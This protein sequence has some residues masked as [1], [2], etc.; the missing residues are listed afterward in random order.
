M[1]E[2]KKKT[3][4][5]KPV[6]LN[7]HQAM[8]AIMRD[9]DGL[10]KDKTSQGGFKYRGIDDVYNYLHDKMALHGVFSL[11]TVHR[12]VREERVSAKGKTLIYTLLEVGYTFYAQDGSSV[13]CMSVGEAF[14]SGDKSAAKALAIAHKYCMFQAFTI[15]TNL[16]VDPDAEVH[17]VGGQETVTNANYDSYPS[18][19]VPAPVMARKDQLAVIDDYQKMGG[20]TDQML[21]YLKERGGRLTEKQADQLIDKLSQEKT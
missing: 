17:Q 11:P 1:S 19:P 13:S 16:S 15:P 6:V 12:V 2:T 20:L 21:E 3:A 5:N 4:V 9:V 18:D 8:I 7:I 14:D 10:V